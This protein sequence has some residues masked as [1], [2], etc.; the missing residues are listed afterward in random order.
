V[1][2]TPNVCRFDYSL[3]GGDGGGAG[4]GSGCAAVI[5]GC[6]EVGG[7]C[8]VG[9]GG[10]FSVSGDNLY[11]RKHLRPGLKTKQRKV[12]AFHVTKLKSAKL[13]I[14][15]LR[16]KASFHS[17]IFVIS[18]KLFELVIILCRKRIWVR[19]NTL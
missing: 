1:S 8:A 17:M 2:T 15:C 3:T 10:G 6:A 19:I 18:S 16:Q 5:G 4:G 12:S 11:A 7:G 14:T 9:G 13:C